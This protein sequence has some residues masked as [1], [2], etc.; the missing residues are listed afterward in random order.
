ML[1]LL[2]PGRVNRSWETDNVE[3]KG[4]TASQVREDNVK[5]KRVYNMAQS[6]KAWDFSNLDQTWHL[7]HIVTGQKGKEK[8]NNQP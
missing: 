5:E 4:A 8:K 3:I 6:W 7:V 2:Q 1:C